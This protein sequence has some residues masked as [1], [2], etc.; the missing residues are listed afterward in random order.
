VPPGALLLLLLVLPLL[1]V[2]LPLL[3]LLLGFLF[4]E[5]SSFDLIL[6]T[7]ATDLVFRDS[8]ALRVPMLILDV[9]PVQ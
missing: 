5:R 6:L 7:S 9:T 4:D 3:L 1:L 8:P 2:L